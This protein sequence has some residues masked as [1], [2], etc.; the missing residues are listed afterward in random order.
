MRGLSSPPSSITLPPSTPAALCNRLF[1]L[2]KDESS[3]GAADL[4]HLRVEYSVQLPSPLLQDTQLDS[5]PQ[6]PQATSLPPSPGSRVRLRPYL[7]V[8]RIQCLQCSE[9]ELPWGRG[10]MVQAR[11]G[12]LSTEERALLS[13]PPP[14]MT[15]P[16][17]SWEPVG[18]DM[19]AELLEH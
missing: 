14:T 10:G 3:P 8:G 18:G 15:R 1:S 5:A 16:D 6:P 2:H 19:Q 12:K 4:T 17:K 7:P 9:G 11:G 13:A